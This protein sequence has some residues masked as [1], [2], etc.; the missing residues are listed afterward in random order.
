MRKSMF[1]I[2]ENKD[3]DQLR[4]NLVCCTAW[5]VSDQVINQNVGFH[6]TWLKFQD[7]QTSGSEEEDF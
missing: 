4:G 5:F 2:C 7:H 1:C 3:A 6:M